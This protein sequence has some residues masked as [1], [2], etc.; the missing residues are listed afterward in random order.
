MEQAHQSVTGSHLLHDLHGEL[1]VVR[2]HVGGGVDRRQ[3]VLGGGDLVVLGL[4]HDPQLPQLVVQILHVF[5][6]SRLDGS[7][8]VVVHLLTLRRL[9]P[10]ERSSAVSEIRALVVHFLRDEEVFLLGTHRGAHV[11]RRVVAEQSEDP[12]RLPV[13][14]LHGA[15]QGGLLVKG[16]TAV[17]AERRGNA[18]RLSFNKRVRRGVP[19][20]VASRLKSGAQA[21][22]GEGGRVRLALYQLFA[23]E[24]H[25]DAAVRG[26][27]DETVVLLRG[28]A[29]QGL[30]PVSEVGRSFGDRPILHGFRHG[31]SHAGIKGLALVDGLSQ[32]RVDL[33]GQSRFHHSVVEHHASESFGYRFHNRSSFFPKRKNRG[34]FPAKNRKDAFA[35]VV[36]NYTPPAGFCQALFFIFPNTAEKSGLASIT[37]LT[38]NK[39]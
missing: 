15:E 32:G 10:K 31:V 18:E 28:D 23:G 21:A 20:G 11:F 37:L 35:S 2:R 1:V 24:F 3:F 34:A 36:G 26:R 27:G 12:E 19:C 38:N 13:Q 29:G 16:V 9:R 22:G 17:G 8:I 33:G 6:H 39:G 30:E 25:D 4:R 7:E 5:R 14:R